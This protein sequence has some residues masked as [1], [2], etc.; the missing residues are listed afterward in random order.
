IGEFPAFTRINV[1]GRNDAVTWVYV[2][3]GSVTGWVSAAYLRFPEGFN[4]AANVPIFPDNVAGVPAGDT[5]TEGSSGGNTASNTGVQP[6]PDVGADGIYVAPED[7]EGGPVVTTPSTTTTTQQT[8]GAASVITGPSNGT[9][10]TAAN[11]RRGPGLQF[12][13]ISLL[14]VNTPINAVGRNGAG[15]WIKVQAVG[16]EGWVFADLLTLNVTRS[17]LPVVDGSAAATTTT[18]PSTT[19]S[20]TAPATTTTQST[21]SYNNVMVGVGPGG[22]PDRD[23]RLNPFTYLGYAIFYCVNAQGYTDRGSFSGG[24]IVIYNYDGPSKGVIFFASEAEINAV[25]VPAEGVQPVKAEA[26]YTLYRRYDG[27]FEMRGINLY[28]EAFIFRW[29]DCNPGPVLGVQ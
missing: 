8:G 15:T 24:G 23:G 20:G 3:N 26:G 21:G 22:S 6:R 18:S 4:V 13:I 27:L 19:E 28:G 10:K 25:G 2:S 12:G 9:V 17:S 5:T 7:G 16:S 1:Y 11:F 29:K 14:T